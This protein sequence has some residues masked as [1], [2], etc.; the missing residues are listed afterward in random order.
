[1][2]EGLYDSRSYN[3]VSILFDRLNHPNADFLTEEPSVLQWQHDD[4]KGFKHLVL[5]LGPPGGAWHSMSYCQYTVSLNYWLEMPEVPFKGWL[6][7]HNLEAQAQP[8]NL[9]KM[10]KEDGVHP[11]RASTNHV[12]LYYSDYIKQTKLDRNF[13]NNVKVTSVSR[14]G[15]NNPLWEINGVEYSQDTGLAENFSVFAKNVVLAVGTQSRPRTLGIPGEN[16][17]F[18]KYSLPDI[19]DFLEGKDINNMAPVIVIGCGLVALDA[20]VAL[21]AYKIPVLHV[22]RRDVKDPKMIINQ[23][24]SSYPDYLKFKQLML[25][26]HANEYYTA[27]PLHKITEILPSKD[28][29]IEHV[30]KKGD[31]FKQTTS[32]VLV[33]IGCK[34]NLSF[35]GDIENLAED[36]TKDVDVKDNPIDVDPVTYESVR[37][38]GLYA[39]GPLIGDN[40]V[41]FIL[42]GALAVTHGLI[43]KS[44]KAKE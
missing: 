30:N 14:V 38:P 18:V 33:Q 19:D 3:P 25:N 44:G 7:E 29:I 24:P 37:E 21:T 40:F 16:L 6:R 8:C 13:L 36:I 26:K 15:A 22:F 4:R 32:L 20:V 43:S 10:T 31:R 1:M 23:L 9:P 42:G 12:A 11:D 41:R 34:P 28:C 2:S 39:I 5:G 27:L 17:G 35:M